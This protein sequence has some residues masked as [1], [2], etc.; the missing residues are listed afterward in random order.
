MKES[1]ERKQAEKMLL[2]VQVAFLSKSGSG[3]FYI[4]GHKRWF[5]VPVVYSQAA[6]KGS[7]EGQTANR[8]VT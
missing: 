8:T 7:S 4:Q 1:V 3:V 2:L 6:G 5:N